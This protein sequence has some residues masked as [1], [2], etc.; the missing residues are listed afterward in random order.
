MATGPNPLLNGFG[1]AMGPLGDL[2]AAGAGIGLASL[3]TPNS[4]SSGPQYP[5]VGKGVQTMNDLLQKGLNQALQYTS[6]AT[7][8]ATGQENT[9]LS[10]STSALTNALKNTTQTATNTLNQGLNQ[11]QAAQAPYSMAGT[12]ALTAYMDSLGLAHPADMLG[13][14]GSLNSASKLNPTLLQNMISAGQAAGATDPYGNPVAPTAPTAPNAAALTGAITPQQIQD[15]LKGNTTT[16]RNVRGENSGYYVKG[17]GQIQPV[18]ATPNK[19][20]IFLVNQGQAQ[21]IDPYAQPSNKPATTMRYQ[22]IMGLNNYNNPQALNQATQNYLG[23]QAY[24]QAQGQYNTQLGTYNNQQMP[25]YNNYV[26][27]QGA[28][29]QNLNGIHPQDLQT[30]LAYQQG[31]FGPVQKV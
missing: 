26:S 13:L 9:A 19:Y 4:G 8:K 6:N 27:A 22:Q 1:N 15:Y 20:G 7:N 24:Q 12:S 5:N 10:N 31:L 29:Q 16:L 21:T 18:N 23:Q 11:Y 2:M 14:Q 25:I 17:V 3:V 28:L 30:A